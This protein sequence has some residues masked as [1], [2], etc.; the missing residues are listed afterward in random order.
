MDPVVTEVNWVKVAAAVSAAIAIGIG[1]LGAAL[2]QGSVG[3]SA[4]E[5]IGKYPES[6][7]KI[8]NAMTATILFIEA[9][10]I[11]TLLIALLLIFK[12]S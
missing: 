8:R 9:S 12:L 11:Y 10:A 1:A 3:S 4:C 5:N 7:D 6:A 2:A